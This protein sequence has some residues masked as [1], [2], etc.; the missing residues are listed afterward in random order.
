MM[1]LTDPRRRHPFAESAEE[2]DSVTRDDLVASLIDIPGKET[3]AL[4]AVIAELASDNDLLV[5]RIGREL[6]NRPRIEPRWLASLSETRTY[7]AVRMVHVLD[8]GDNIMLGVRLPDGRKLT[9]LVYIDHNVGTLVKDAFVIPDAIERVEAKQRELSDDPDTR[10]EDLSLADARVWIDDAIMRAAVTFPPFESED[11]PS[12]RA[13]VEW[14]IRGLPAGGS[15]YPRTEWSDEDRA[16]IAARFF[17]SSSGAP[18]D[19]GDHRELLDTLLWYGTDYG[20]GTPL[21]WSPVRV[22]ILLDDWL[23]RKIVAPAEYLAKAPDLLRAFIRF[24][25]A[26]VGIRSELT[27]EVLAA[28]DQWD[29]VYQQTIRSDRPQGAEAI[30]AA[31]G[32]GPGRWDDPDDLGI[33]EWGLERLARDVGGA[34]ALDALDDDPLPDEPFQ[35]K[36]IPNDIVDRVD[37]V[38]DLVERCCD[39]L[40]DVE[41]RTAC[42]R[43]LTRIATAGPEVFRR[44][45]RPETAAAAVV[46]VIGK[47]NEVFDLYGY[48]GGLQVNELLSHFGLTGSA[49]Q[50]AGTLLNAA[51]FDCDTHDLSLQS[52]EYLVASRRRD[53][54]E[55]RNQYRDMADRSL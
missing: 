50:R 13:L 18:M 41:C 51:G 34:A 31:M 40:L 30:L 49:S 17:A 47:V 21:K 5:A 55:A 12:C 46:W 3:T 20:P 53:I 24:A 27:E 26:E 22:E 36:N 11:W 4:L 9:C 8:D 15:E 16:A 37:D 42:R 2:A 43:L 25:H 1:L 35:R 33:A 54:I 23:P 45:G 38:L 14:I 28:V 7:R 6:A 52:P 48:G 39:E 29:P 32:L 19:D 44:K 10:W